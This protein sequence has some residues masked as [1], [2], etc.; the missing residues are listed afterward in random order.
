M[1][2]MFGSS[3]QASG[4]SR[5][6]QLEQLK[7]AAKGNRAGATVLIAVSIFYVIMSTPNVSS[8]V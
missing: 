4:S 5:S 6:H 7:R 8:L 1:G 3:R 2:R